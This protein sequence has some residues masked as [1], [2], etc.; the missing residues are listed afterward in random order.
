VPGLSLTVTYNVPQTPAENLATIDASVTNP[1]DGNYSFSNIYY[2]LSTQSD[3]EYL[4]A[5]RANTERSI[6]VGAS[7]LYYD[8][9]AKPVSIFGIES[10]DFTRATILVVLT[11]GF[12]SL[13][14]GNYI[15]AGQTAFDTGDGFFF[16]NT[17]GTSQT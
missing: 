15:A 14:S 13:G 10:E 1:A 11:A 4:F 16:G 5:G 2:K 3:S 17:G 9:I 7:G 12:V 8:V 6:V